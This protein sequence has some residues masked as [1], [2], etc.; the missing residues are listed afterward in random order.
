MLAGLKLTVTPDGMPLADIVMELLNPPKMAAVIVDV[1][2]PPCAA[3]TELGLAV[4]VNPG[5]VPEVTASE[6]MVVW[7]IPPPLPV[8]VM[9]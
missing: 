8:T 5:A 6:T 9:V 7:V 4:R 3:V 2:L 1:P